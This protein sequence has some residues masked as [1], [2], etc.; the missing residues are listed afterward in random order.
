MNVFVA[1]S[2]LLENKFPAI[3][4]SFKNRLYILRN[5]LVLNKQGFETRLRLNTQ[6]RLQFPLFLTGLVIIMFYLE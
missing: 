4:A 6:L 1:T 5:S 2:Y 3:Y